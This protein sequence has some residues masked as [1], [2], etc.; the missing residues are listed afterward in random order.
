MLQKETILFFLAFI[1]GC[2]QGLYF[3]IGETER[4][5]FI[6]ELPDDVTVIGEKLS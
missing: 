2:T 5:C 6:E 3:H 1:I 4:K